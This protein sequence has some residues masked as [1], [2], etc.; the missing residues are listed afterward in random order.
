MKRWVIGFKMFAGVCGY[1]S[2]TAS[3]H[4]CDW[5]WPEKIIRCR[6]R[7]C[8]VLKKCKEIPDYEKQAKYTMLWIKR[9][10]VAQERT[11]KSTLRFDAKEGKK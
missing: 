6:S 3:R 10:L 7:D 8:P 4:E 1:R 11:R 2:K 9:L 5:H